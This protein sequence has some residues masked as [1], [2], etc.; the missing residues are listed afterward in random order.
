MVFLRQF[1]C[2]SG[3]D[4]FGTCMILYDLVCQEGVIRGG[5]DNHQPVVVRPVVRLHP[6][7]KHGALV[8][9]KVL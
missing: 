6:F 3:S 4:L 7:S 8:I 1:S 2:V 9:E 5:V